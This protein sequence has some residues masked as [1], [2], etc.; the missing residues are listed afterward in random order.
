MASGMDYGSSAESAERSMCRKFEFVK[1][2]CRK[3][4]AWFK[5]EL[6]VRRLSHLTRPK[7]SRNAKPFGILQSLC[8][9]I[10]RETKSYSVHYD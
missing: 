10:D 7:K 5:F 8:W 9:K 4:D 6:A 3:F 2:E 1:F